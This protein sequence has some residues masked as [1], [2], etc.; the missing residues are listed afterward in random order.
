MSISTYAIPKNQF[1][2]PDIEGLHWTEQ[3]ITLTT[4]ELG[5]SRVS[6]ELNTERC[7]RPPARLPRYIASS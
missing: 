3:S 7:L 4:N 2:F 6:I 5:L 1:V